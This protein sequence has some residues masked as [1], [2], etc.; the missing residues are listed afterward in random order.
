MLSCANYGEEEVLHNK[1]FSSWFYFIL[2]YFYTS[3]FMQSLFYEEYSP[4]FIIFF[5]SLVISLVIFGASFFISVQKPDTEKL[6]A[7]E[8]GFDPYGDARN[9]F[10]VH[11][12]IVAILFIIFDLEAMFLFPF[13]ISVRHVNSFGFWVILDFI[14]ELIVGFIYA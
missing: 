7:Y 1:L 8:C 10:D 2:F 13:V 14:I 5:I 11:F 9:A 3:F 4:T 6:S 12:Y